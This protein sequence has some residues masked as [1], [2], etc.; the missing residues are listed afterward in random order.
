MS[1]Y[2]KKLLLIC[3]IAFLLLAELFR[4][5]EYS[6]QFSHWRSSVHKAWKEDYHHKKAEEYRRENEARYNK[7]LLYVVARYDK[8][9]SLSRRFIVL[10]T[11]TADIQSGKAIVFA[12]KWD[13]R[14]SV[15]CVKLDTTEIILRP[16]LS[17]NRDTLIVPQ[18]ERK[19]LW[20]AID[21]VILKGIVFR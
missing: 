12:H 19:V 4:K 20:Y 18:Y 3:C 15:R 1:Q 11:S 8:K 7:H 21:S 9:D 17:G 10:N 5:I 6:H 2:S 16:I 14:G 13:R